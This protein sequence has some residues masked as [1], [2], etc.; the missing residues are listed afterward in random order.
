MVER[1]HRKVCMKVRVLVFFVA[2]VC[3]SLSIAQ[4]SQKLQEYLQQEQQRKRSEAMRQMDSGVFYM[5][6]GKY[7]LADEKFRYVLQHIN[8][9][10][11]DLTFFF[12]KNSFHLGMFRQSVDWLNKYIQ[13]KG[14]TGR[15]YEE[16]VALLKQCEAGLV[17]EKA[18]DAKKVAEVLS[19]NFDIDCGPSGK[20]IC[21]VCKGDR[22]IMRRGAFGNEYKTCPYCDDH[23]M[24][25]CK[26]YN[27]LL[28][29]QLKPKT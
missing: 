21:P 11:S 12:G 5:D 16:S 4:E 17:E 8:S 26:E 3:P 1:A 10:P 2:I 13:L 15:F 7:A 20:V 14:T 29:G 18:E 27:S 28:R 19:N 24:L 9:I 22:V 25:T 23:G 6:A